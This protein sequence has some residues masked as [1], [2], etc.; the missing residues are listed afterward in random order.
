MTSFTTS[1]LRASSQLKRSS[2]VLITCGSAARTAE[3][4]SCIRATMPSSRTAEYGASSKPY[5]LSAKKMCPDISPASGLPV[6]AIF[7]LISE[8]PVF[9]ISG[10]P[11]AFATSSNST[12]EAFTS[13]M[14]VLPGFAFSTSR[15]STISNWSPNRMWP[16]LSTTP[17]RSPSPSKAMPRSAFSRATSAMICS[18]FFATVG[19]GWWFGKVPSTSPLMT[20]CVP[21]RR[22]ASAFTIGPA[23]PLPGSH[24]TLS[25]R[26]PPSQ[27]CSTRSA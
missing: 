5:H 23:E 10:L 11:P 17:M 9:H 20:K 22:A 13:A 4:L 8:W 27:S 14:M 2:G 16:S 1:N 12:W 7:A 6:S 19:S 25:L 18:R 3:R 26:S 24:T 21:G 15:A